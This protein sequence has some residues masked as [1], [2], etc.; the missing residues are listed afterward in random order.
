M[1]LAVDIGNTNI[2]L[3]VFAGEELRPG[4]HLIEQYACGEDVGPA[5]HRL[6][7]GLLGGHVRDLSL[8]DPG[9]GVGY[10]HGRLGDPEIHDLNLALVGDQ[11]VLWTDVAVDDVERPIVLVGLSVRVIKALADLGGDVHGDI[12]SPGIQHVPDRVP[13]RK[14]VQCL[15]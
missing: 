15:Q 4:E 3:G 13:Q 14:T 12:H 8:Q 6:A 5:I 11:D 10:V 9:H 7:H 2:T 1:L